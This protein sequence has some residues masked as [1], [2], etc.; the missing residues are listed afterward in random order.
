MNTNALLTY[1]SK[2]LNAV[3]VVFYTVAILVIFATL[4]VLFRLTAAVGA[5]RQR[6]DVSPWIKGRL[7]V[8]P[9][10]EPNQPPR[11]GE[12]ALFLF[13]SKQDRINIPGDLEEEYRHIES[14]FGARPATIWY[15]KQVATSIAP[16]LRKCFIKWVT[17]A[18]VEEWVRRHL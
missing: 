17:I 2:V 7:R 5:S 3:A 10:R 11:L 8:F 12:Y 15:Y 6:L 4:S 14:K 1:S 9:A 18:W 13:L 16:L